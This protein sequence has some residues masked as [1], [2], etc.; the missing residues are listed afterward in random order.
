MALAKRAG[1]N[2]VGGVEPYTGNPLFSYECRTAAH[3]LNSGLPERPGDA[4]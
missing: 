4:E 3:G 1:T 2:F